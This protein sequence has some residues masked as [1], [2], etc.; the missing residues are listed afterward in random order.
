ML[1]ALSHQER[2]TRLNQ[3]QTDG[4]LEN[5]GVPNPQTE[6]GQAYTGN[7]FSPRNYDH[8]VTTEER[9]RTNAN[10]VIQYAPSDNLIVTAD[11]LYSDFD[12][13]TDTTSYGHWFT[14]PNIEGFGDDAGATVDANGTVI[15]LYQEVG[16]ATDMHAKKFDRLTESNALGLNFDWDVND[17]LNMKF[18]I[19]HSSAKREANNGRGDQLSLIGYANRVRYQI[20]NNILPYANEFQSANSAI[21]SGQQEINGDAYNPA[22]TPD[23]VSDHLDPTN[24]RAHVCYVVVGLLKILLINC[25]GTV[26]GLMMVIAV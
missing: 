4:W 22:I 21:Y 12:V 8:K 9:T 25:A 3:A 6:S 11:A 14:A 20:D 13:E 5:V 18:D 15:D 24:S 10:L 17:N 23:G 26:F 16:L 1:F 19:S 2:E 7:I